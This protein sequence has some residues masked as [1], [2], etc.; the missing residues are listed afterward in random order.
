MRGLA[1]PGGRLVLDA[2][3]GTLA[4]GAVGGALVTAIS[5]VSNC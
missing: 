4:F 1:R 2:L 5:T 3:A